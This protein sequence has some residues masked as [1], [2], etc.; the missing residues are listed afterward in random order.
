LAVA[1]VVP[2]FSDAH[3]QELCKVL[4]DSATGTELTRLLADARVDDSVGEGATKW[5]RLH[6]ALAERQRRDGHANAVCGFIRR[7]MEPVRFSDAPESYDAMREALNIR[8]AFA[9]LRVRDDG[10]VVRVE[11]SRTLTEAQER[12]DALKARL[13]ERK[14]HPDVLRFCRPELVQKNYFHA[15]FEATKS[16]AEK[17]RT[18]S[19]YTSDGSRL[20]DDALGIGSSGMPALA[21]N[22][23]SNETER[24][25]HAGLTM[26]IKG[27]FGTF[28]NT[29][30]HA[31]K[32]TWPIG[33]EDALDLLTLASLLH[34]RLDAAH[35]T[36]AAPA[37]QT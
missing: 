27:M 36:P 37:N 30:A 29:T 9:G 25:E 18:L 16:V 13:K 26:L 1:T 21:F 14:V 20:V 34:R 32:I 7:V 31:P 17:I 19:G 23:L 8:L 3:L 33:L 11:M 22:M 10:Q 6:A 15:V 4:G 35:V 5:R 2:S 28:R 12:A 24:S